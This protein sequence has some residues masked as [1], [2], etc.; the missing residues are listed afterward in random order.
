MAEDQPPTTPPRRTE[1][2]DVRVSAEEK[3][4]LRVLAAH[5][6]NGDVSALIRLKTLGVEPDALK[7]EP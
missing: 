1:R 3:R 7:V 2:L 4:R 5:E 6:T